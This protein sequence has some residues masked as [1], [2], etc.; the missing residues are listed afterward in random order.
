MKSIL[1][2]LKGGDLR[3]IGKANEVIRAVFD[4]PKLFKEVFEG[5]TDSDPVI[6]MR[7]ADVTEKVSKK[8]PE[9]LQPF[10]TRLI[11]E[12]AKIPQQEVRWHV[13]KMF[14]YLKLTPTEKDKITGYLFSWISSD[15][16]SKIVKVMSLQTLTDFAMRDKKLQGK[17][18]KK[19]REVIRDGSPA[20]KSRSKKLL[21]EFAAREKNHK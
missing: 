17:V 13:A 9:Y 18:I 7:S 8:H 19:L 14:S 6:R 21:K 2:K 10:K 20:I 15:D 1:G 11:N 4:N 16:K 3:S 5:M 12:V